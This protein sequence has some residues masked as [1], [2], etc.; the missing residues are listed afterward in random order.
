METRRITPETIEEKIVWYSII[1]TWGF[2]VLGALYVVAPVIGWILF[3]IGFKKLC[4]DLIVGGNISRFGISWTVLSW[5]FGMFV[6]LI[7][8]IVGHLNYDIGLGPIIKSSIGW[9]KGWALLALFPFIGCLSIRSELVIRA[10]CVVGM[11]TLIAVPIFVLAWLVGAPQVLY[12]SPIQAVGGPGPEFF[13]V[14]LYEIDPGS[15]MPRWRMFTPWAPALGFVANVY[16]LCALSEKDLRWKAAG[17]LGAI[18]MILMSQSRLGIVA[19]LVVPFITLGISHIS[20]PLMLAA[21]GIATAGLGIIMSPLIAAADVVMTKFSEARADSSRVRAALGRI[22]LQRWQSEA[23]IWGHGVVERGPHMVE[24][25]PIGSHHTWY[26]LLFVKGIVGL[27]A[28]LVPMIVCLLELSIKSSRHKEARLGLGMV[29][30]L[31][32]Y[33]FGE[34]LEVL[35]YLIWPGLLFIG[36]GARPSASLRW[37]REQRE[38]SAKIKDASVDPAAG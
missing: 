38:K 31:F 22:A 9:A 17:M 34:N 19:A 4:E 13:M 7:A 27:A 26:G 5:F 12:V 8:L 24:F 16:M 21:G 32:L 11:H 15:G 25:M 18:F 6:M 2:Y 23:P 1:W 36:M 28:L 10:C 3:A 35:A 37:E 30:L 33:T 14:S 29:L 20:H